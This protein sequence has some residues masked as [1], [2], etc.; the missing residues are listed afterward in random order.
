MAPS[1]IRASLQ[2]PG[3][4]GRRHYRDSFWRMLDGVLSNLHSTFD[5]SLPQLRARNFL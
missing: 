1:P 2:H 3:R 4:V 5:A